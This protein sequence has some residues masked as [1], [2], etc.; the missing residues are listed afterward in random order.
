MLSRSPLLKLGELL[1]N[2]FT[3]AGLRPLLSERGMDKG[4]DD[5]AIEARPESTAELI[6]RD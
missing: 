3:D 1:R 6:C 2:V 4:L 5:A